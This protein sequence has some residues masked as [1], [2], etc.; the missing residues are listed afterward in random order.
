MVCFFGVEWI[1]EQIWDAF[2]GL[3]SYAEGRHSN[4]DMKSMHFF[5]ELEL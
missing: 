3:G 5:G 1:T 2:T 4:I